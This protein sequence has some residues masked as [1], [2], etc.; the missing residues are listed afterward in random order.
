M[1]PSGQTVAYHTVQIILL[2]WLIYLIG[3]Q[4]IHGFREGIVRLWWISGNDF[5]RFPRRTRPIPYW[6]VL[7]SYAAWMAA[8]VWLL[9]LDF[10]RR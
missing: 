3:S 9:F 8:I 10:S 6:C 4:L 1:I 5:V 7:A 2:V